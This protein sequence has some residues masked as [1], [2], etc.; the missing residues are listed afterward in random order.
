MRELLYGSGLRLFECLR[1]RVK[2]LDFGYGQITVGDGKGMRERL[3][4]LLERVRGPLQVHLENVR[5]M[6]DRDRARGAGR[7]Y[8]P[9]AL[10]RKYPGTER[11]WIWQ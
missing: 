8:L 11:A 4:V 3:T 6:H 5:Q 10:A 1:L 9:S 7:V 2:D